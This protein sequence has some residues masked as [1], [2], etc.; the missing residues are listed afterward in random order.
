VLSFSP[1]VEMGLPQPLTRRRVCP[2]PFGS[3]GGGP[4]AGGGGGGGVPIRLL[5]KSLA[6]CLVCGKLTLWY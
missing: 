2:P 3:G 4:L 1:A 6:L 5:E